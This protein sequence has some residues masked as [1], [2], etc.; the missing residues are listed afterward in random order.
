M[1]Q[2]FNDYEKRISSFNRVRA[3]I[4]TILKSQPNL[5]VEEVSKEFLRRYGFLPRIG[6]RLR[7]DRAAGFVISTIDIKGKLRWRLAP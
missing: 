5:T 7:E 2:Q 3:Q 6:N 1:S 4:R